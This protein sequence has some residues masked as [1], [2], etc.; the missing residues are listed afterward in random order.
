MNA[1]LSQAEG[2]IT[3]VVFQNPDN[4][5]TVARLKTDPGEL[6]TIVGTLP[7]TVVGERL[8][9]EGVW[10]EHSTYGRQLELRS[11]ERNLPDSRIGI[12]AYLSSRSIRGIGPKLAARIVDR[13]GERSLDVIEHEHRLLTQISGISAAKAEEIH[14]SFLAQ[15]GLRLLVEFLGRHQLPVELA[16]RIYRAYGELSLTIIEDDPYCLTQEPIG[17][18]FAQVDRFALDMG[19]DGDD[20][21]RV[22]AGI[23]Y[24]LRYNI[25][26]GHVFL[27]CR[28]LTELTAGFLHLEP[29]AVREGI[30]RLQEQELVTL[31]TVAGQEAVYLPQFSAAERYL[32]GRF[33]AMAETK[34]PP[35]P[36]LERTLRQIEGDRRIEY[37][38]LQREAI[39]AAAT[40]QLLII[41]GG[42]GTGKTTILKGILDLYD[43]Q[44]LKTLLAAPTGRAAKRLTELTGRD[45]STIHRLLEVDVA[46]S[47]ED[48]MIFLRNERNPLSCDA[49]IVDETSMVDL[50]LMYALVRALPLR[51]RLI[52]V[53][54]PD[55]LPSVGPGNVFSDLIRSERIRTIRLTD[56]FRQ[57]RESLII[58]NAHRINSGLLPELEDRS[59]DFFFLPRQSG[60]AVCQAVTDLC[61]RRLP[62]KL[63]IPT[64]DIQVLTPTRK[65]ETGTRELNRL[66]QAAL[67][68]PA[69]G[70]TE[71]KYG[72]YTY[73][74]GDRVM[75][76]RNNYDIIWRKQGSDRP[77][78]GIFNGDVG[79]ITEID[80]EGQTLTIRFDDREAVYSFDLLP[81][82]E[83]AFAMTVH[84]SQGSEYR[85]VVLCAWR[86]TPLLLSRSVLYTAVTRARELLILVGEREVISYMVRNDKKQKRFSGLCWRLR[87][88]IP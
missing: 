75:Q 13:F 36:H 70:K 79:L 16:V 38:E 51:C 30:L 88:E 52:F 45:A 33:P 11:A 8:R 50:P 34:L 21:R 59:G 48:D 71:K 18:A 28:T 62:E 43:R 72:D 25:G 32:A 47:N 63:G 86:G 20:E 56:I 53:G 55:Q 83:P 40:E 84:K 27:P 31:E 57:A 17:A 2:C 5:Y 67:N 19:F 46:A 12:L 87:R 44:G 73:R 49:V 81:Q 14:E 58:T 15:Q 82:I 10:T 61:R 41:T 64:E 42:P 6:I 37:A 39:R 65:G 78:T 35:P 26:G 9:V 60:T 68:P 76:I 77:G 80:A 69:P 85:A 74:V 23:L 22:D 3:A 29:E 7:Q 66:L 24:E 54:D 1:E 4:G